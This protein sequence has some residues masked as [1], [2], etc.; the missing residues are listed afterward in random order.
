[1][2]SIEKLQN[3]CA[4]CWKSGKNA[5]DAYIRLWLEFIKLPTEAKI[6]LIPELVKKSQYYPQLIS[7]AKELFDS[8]SNAEQKKLEI[9]PTLWFGYGNV[10]ITEGEYQYRK[11]KGLPA[12]CYGSS[13]VRPAQPCDGIYNRLVQ[14]MAMK[15]GSVVIVA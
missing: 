13:Y 7:L 4:E 14:N 3:F 5:H 10:F 1:M 6:D 15:S 9:P 12:E 8:L 2:T 11:A